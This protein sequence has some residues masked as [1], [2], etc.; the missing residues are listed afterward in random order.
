MKNKQTKAFFSFKNDDVDLVELGQFLR[1]TTGF[2]VER[3]WHIVFDKRPDHQ[4]HNAVYC[5]T[6]EKGWHSRNPDLM[7][8]D[9]KSG[10]LILVIELDGDIH[11]ID[12]IATNN[13]NA[14]YEKAG[15]D[16]LVIKKWEIETSIFDYISHRLE[17]RL[18]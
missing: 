5:K 17:E 14:E 8:I 15:I 18:G 9:K 12:E 2:R 13:R 1:D 6:I 16:M 7:L 10:K 11:R 3:E 4:F